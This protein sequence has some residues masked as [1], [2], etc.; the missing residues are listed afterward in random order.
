MTSHT[1]PEEGPLSPITT[2]L[3]PGS[4]ENV[5]DDIEREFTI[6][7]AESTAAGRPRLSVA[8]EFAIQQVASRGILGILQ[9]MKVRGAAELADQLDTKT[10][11]DSWT[12]LVSI[13]QD[14]RGKLFNLTSQLDALRAE[15]DDDQAQEE[16]DAEAEERW[17]QER[18][19]AGQIP[20]RQRL[21]SLADA[22]NATANAA[23]SAFTKPEDEKHS[24]MTLSTIARARKEVED[25]AAPALVEGRNSS[26]GSMPSHALF[27]MLAKI[28]GD[29]LPEGIRP[30][31]S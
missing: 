4:F 6:L 8:Q 12:N 17:D 13:A 3:P 5:R 10:A 2:P 14:Q 24:E 23:I 7:S 19:L 31:A 21:V 18:K 30:A 20:S 29:H 27:E 11:D 28:E 9:R 1:N 22:V 25:A 26:I 15:E 16:T